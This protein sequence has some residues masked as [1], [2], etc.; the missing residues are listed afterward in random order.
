MSENEPNP[1]DFESG[2]DSSKEKEKSKQF[3]MLIV[4]GF[5]V[6]Y[7]EQ[8]KGWQLPAGAK[9]RILAA[10][11]L[12]KMG[13]I[14]KIVLS[15][16]G[17]PDRTSGGQLMKEYLVTH[18]PDIP[19]DNIVVE[20]SATNTIENF[21]GVVDYIDETTEAQENP[22]DLNIAFLSN[23]FHMPR[24]N[25]LAE[26]FE[27]KGT[28]F[29]AEEVLALAAANREKEKGIPTVDR[30]KNLEYLMS[31]PQGNEV[32]RDPNLIATREYSNLIDQLQIDCLKE[33]DTEKKAQL[34]T[35]R[36]DIFTE[37]QRDEADQKL[38]DL[39]VDIESLKSRIAQKIGAKG[40]TSYGTFLNQENRWDGGLT[41]MP[42]YWLYQAAKVNSERFKKML[43]SKENEDA[44]NLIIQ[45]GYKNPSEMSSE[46]FEQMRKEIS[47]DD[48]IKNNRK[49]PPAEWEEL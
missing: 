34:E 31:N 9:A 10:G 3:D 14:N 12:W 44:F 36:K 8:D 27:I 2:N 15:E 40:A 37:K 21:A 16:G 20:D 45:L 47:S 1:Q 6:K 25:D 28:V 33:G 13:D 35:L 48:F 43:F 39:G 41:Q 18:Y 19:E 46:E 24:I 29:S 17:Q 22:K 30:V 4:F 7:N 26:R 23:R 11:E 32:L 5:G 42:E 38:T 49:V